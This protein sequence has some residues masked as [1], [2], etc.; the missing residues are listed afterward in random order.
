M[1]AYD[2]YKSTA[3]AFERQRQARDEADAHWHSDSWVYW[4]QQNVPPKDPRWLPAWL[5]THDKLPASARNPKEQREARLD[6]LKDAF[7]DAARRAALQRFN[8]GRS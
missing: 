2:R 7:Y 3:A 4:T 1:S 6:A 8:L 5:S